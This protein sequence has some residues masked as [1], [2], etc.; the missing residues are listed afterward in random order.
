MDFI[1]WR[2]RKSH[3]IFK[4]PRCLHVRR[5]TPHLFRP[6]EIEDLSYIEAQKAIK[7][8]GSDLGAIAVVG[9]VV[10]GLALLSD[11]SKKTLG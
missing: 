10:L 11:A 1:R 4:C 5:L 2:W 7:V 9:T 3:N 8:S 6:D